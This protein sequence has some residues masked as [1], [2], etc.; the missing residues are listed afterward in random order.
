MSEA[1]AGSQ[2][3]ERVG[4][5]SSLSFSCVA[6]RNSSGSSSPGLA[7][8]YFSTLFCTPRS[9]TPGVLARPHALVPADTTKVRQ[10]GWETSPGGW[11]GLCQPSQCLLFPALCGILGFKIVEMVLYARFFELINA[12][13]LLMF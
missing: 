13:D 10:E 2:D 6:P 12:R 1:A 7:L 4:G 11:I 9:S 3:L 8:S 5:T